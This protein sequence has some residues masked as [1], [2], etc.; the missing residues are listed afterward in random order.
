MPDFMIIGML[1]ACAIAWKIRDSEIRVQRRKAPPVVRATQRCP[2]C[3][4]DGCVIVDDPGR[5]SKSVWGPALVLTCTTCGGSG[6]VLAK[7]N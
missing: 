3:F 4:G 7:A 6:E 2:W 5:P 1:I